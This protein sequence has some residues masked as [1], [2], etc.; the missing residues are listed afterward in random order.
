VFVARGLWSLCVVV[1][2]PA[3]VFQVGAA[4]VDVIVWDR[5]GRAFTC[6]SNPREPIDPLGYLRM[7]LIEAVEAARRAGLPCGAERR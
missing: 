5:Q 1:D 4:P 3:I 7:R 2:P 6:W